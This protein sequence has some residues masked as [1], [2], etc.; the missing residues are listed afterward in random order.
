M[1][2]CDLK[3]NNFSRVSV[4]CAAVSMPFFDALF[5]NKEET[6]NKR[7]GVAILDLEASGS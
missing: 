6:K 2:A 1:S 4:H 3:K 5:F 7:A